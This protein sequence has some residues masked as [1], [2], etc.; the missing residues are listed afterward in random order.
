[1]N[2]SRWLDL[3]KSLGVA[4]SLETYNKL[5]RA[6]SEPHRYYH[7]EVHIND[8]LSELD[9]VINL[10]ENAVEVETA[11]WFHDAI[12]RPYAFD[13]ERVRRDHVLS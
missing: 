7:T 8:C 10:T 3:M 11:I 5:K 2:Q 4:P 13:N 9:S 6:Y 1:M 12:Y